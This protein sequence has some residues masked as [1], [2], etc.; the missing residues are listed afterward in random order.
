MLVVAEDADSVDGGSATSSLGG[1][2]DAVNSG[3]GAG[4]VDVAVG[5]LGDSVGNSAPSSGSDDSGVGSGGD[6]GGVDDCS[7]DVSGDGVD[8]VDW[9]PHRPGTFTICPFL[10]LMQ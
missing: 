1:V 2:D 3:N 5:S 10:T 8:D 4:S 6:G 7:A 9:V